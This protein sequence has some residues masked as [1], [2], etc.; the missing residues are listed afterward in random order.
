M[1]RPLSRLFAFLSLLPVF[2]GCNDHREPG[3]KPQS[4]QP[5]GYVAP[6]STAHLPLVDYPEYVN[7]NQFPV[8]TYVVRKKEVTNDF[9]LVR[10]TTKLSLRERTA[11]RVVVE[12]QVTVDRPGESLVENPPQEMQFAAKFRLPAGTTIEQFLL[13]SLKAKQVGEEAREEGGREFKAQVFAWVERNETG[14]MAI[15]L[16]RSDDVPGRMLRQEIEGHQHHSIEQVVEIVVP[17]KH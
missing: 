8:G 5:E 6:A 13:P 7:W 15:K 11:E 2:P 9:G 16:W 1:I 10:V 14:P 3:G 4:S 12:S 17:Q